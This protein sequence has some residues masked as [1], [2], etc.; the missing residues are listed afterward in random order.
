MTTKTS[1][2]KPTP[3]ISPDGVLELSG[4]PARDLARSFNVRVI[5]FLAIHIPLVFVLEAF[6][7]IST[8]FALLVLAFGI[9][10]ALLSKPSQ[11]LYA[12][13]YIA[14]AEVLWRMT[15]ATIPWEFAKYATVVII[16]VAILVEWSKADRARRLRSP[17]PVLL[18]VVLLPGA[19]F[20]ILENDLAT[21]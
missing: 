1:P 20:A 9:R 14:G 6:P 15:R 13:A 4:N 8:V 18:I 2:T 21:R 7:V 5:L 10:A 19:L 11:V 3:S 12:V 16:A 17:W